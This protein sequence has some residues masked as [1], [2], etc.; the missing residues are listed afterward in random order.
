MLEKGE[1]ITLYVKSKES[2]GREELKREE[3]KRRNMGLCLK[4]TNESET[5]A[6]GQG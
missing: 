2:V 1:I 4:G 5:G 6:K 3:R